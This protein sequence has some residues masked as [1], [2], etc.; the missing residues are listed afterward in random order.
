MEKV[1]N[2]HSWSNTDLVGSYEGKEGLRQFLFVPEDPP[3]EESKIGKLLKSSGASKIRAVFRG[4]RILSVTPL[5][6]AEQ[7]SAQEA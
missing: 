6:F 2:I 7:P 4:S 3:S 1:I 5:N